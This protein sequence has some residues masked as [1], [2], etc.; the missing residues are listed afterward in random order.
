MLFCLLHIHLVLALQA[1]SIIFGE[2]E[3]ISELLYFHVAASSHR[4]F[5]FHS[6]SFDTCNLT[7]A[8]G[9]FLDYHLFSRS[10]D[11]TLFIKVR[12]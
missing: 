1:I 6:L 2:K 12:M 3:M 8:R 4:C 9:A 7:I 5:R 11:Y 10:F